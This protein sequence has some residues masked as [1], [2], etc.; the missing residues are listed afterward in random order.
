VWYAAKAYLFCQLPVRLQPT[1]LSLKAEDAAKV[2]NGEEH[3]QQFLWVSEGTTS[4][5][6]NHLL[7]KF[8]EQGVDESDI[9]GKSRLQHCV[10]S[11]RVIS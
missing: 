4:M 2:H 10:T 9:V 1:V 7:F 3:Y 11:L 6:G 5:R 8:F